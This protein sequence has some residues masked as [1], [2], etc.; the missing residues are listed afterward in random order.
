VQQKMVESYCG[1]QEWEAWL[2]STKFP[3]DL[4]REKQ[5]LFFLVSSS[6]YVNVTT[7]SSSTRSFSENYFLSSN[8]PKCFLLVA[9]KKVLQSYNLFEEKQRRSIAPSNFGSFFR[10]RVT[11]GILSLIFLQFIQT[12]PYFHTLLGG[13]RSIF[14]RKDEFSSSYMETE[15]LIR[16]WPKRHRVTLV[17]AD[18]WNEK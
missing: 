7:I 13:Q 16:T 9:E 18:I 10:H 14:R 11:L 2:T 12:K 1:L 15:K 17:Q 4:R 8:R 5:C 3:E 6:R